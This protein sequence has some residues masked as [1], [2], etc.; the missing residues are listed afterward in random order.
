MTFS[1]HGWFE[2]SDS[3]YESES[4]NLRTLAE[5][6]AE[7]ILELG[8]NDV[9]ELRWMNGSCMLLVH[10]KRNRPG[11]VLDLLRTLFARLHEAG[12]SGSFGLAHYQDDDERERNGF[13]TL[14]LRRGVLDELDDVLLSPVIP[15]IEDR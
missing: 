9:A 1:L 3:A 12:G 13:G 8:L 2:L 5:N 6:A 10:V 14:R 7:Q 15:S 4:A 11:Q